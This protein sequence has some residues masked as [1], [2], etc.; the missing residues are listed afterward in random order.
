MHHSVSKSLLRACPPFLL[1]VA[2]CTFAL[3]TTVWLGG[4]NSVVNQTTPFNEADLEPYLSSGTAQLRGHAF[5]RS[6]TA[7]KHGAAGL[8]I[9]LV[10]L[11]PYTEEM[12]TIMESGKTP[13]PADPRLER[14]TR[15]TIGDWGGAYVF[16]HLPA[17]RYLIYCRVTWEAQNPAGLRRDASGA[18]Y[19]VRRTDVLAGEKKDVVVTN[20]KTN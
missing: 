5:V 4:C 12:A 8:K 20:V 18:F 1:R 6:D 14:Y 9:F 3:A 2:L 7:I 11:T 19:A 13:G 17:G 15:T 10:P 16:D